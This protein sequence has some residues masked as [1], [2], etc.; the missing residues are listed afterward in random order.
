MS[1]LKTQVS[2]LRQTVTD[3]VFRVAGFSSRGFARKIFA[4]FI[5]PPANKFAKITAEFDYQVGTLG[6][7]EAAVNLLRFFVDE[8]KTSG[9]E[10]I[11]QEGPLV[12]ASNHPGTYDGL[13]IMSSIPRD[14]M[15]VVVQGFPFVQNMKA[16]SRHL[17]Y[18]PADL[19]G[20]MGVVRTMIR[21]L[22]EGGGLLVFPSGKLEP[23]PEVLPGAMESLNEWSRSIGLIL[24]RVPDTQLLVTIV[25]GV[26]AQSSLNN[27]FTRF[28]DDIWMKIRAA[29]FLQIIQQ[30]L[31]NKKFDLIPKISFSDPITVDD[32]LARMDSSSVMVEIVQRARELMEDHLEELPLLVKA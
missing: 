4:P 24:N 11:P 9:A 12:I 32:L 21:H 25:S 15:K 3:E 27:P 20:R 16:S 26:L 10:K 7:R 14:D 8:I 23:D 5:W 6:Y 22:K 19:H 28:F 17:I 1:D 29:E 30:L 13:A 2:V 31:I 18:T